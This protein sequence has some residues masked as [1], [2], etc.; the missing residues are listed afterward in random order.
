[1]SFCVCIFQ[2]F[3]SHGALKLKQGCDNWSNT[4]RQGQDYKLV[5]IGKILYFVGTWLNSLA[6][7][8]IFLTTLK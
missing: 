8:H 6:I 3:I 4:N 1:M 7:V 5:F 2:F